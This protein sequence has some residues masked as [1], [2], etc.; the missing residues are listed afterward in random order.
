MNGCTAT[1]GTVTI[2]PQLTATSVLT[3]E[4]DCSAS[5][6]AVIDVTIN[7]GYAPFA[8]QVNGGASTPVVGNAFTYTTATD[9]TFVFTITD[10]EGCTAETTVVVDPITNPVATHNATDP[11]C[12]GASDGQVEILIDTNFG[13]APYQ[14]DFD[15]AGF[16][17]QTVFSNLAAGTYNYLSLIHI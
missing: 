17:T 9:G 2:E 4:L 8:Y 13:T 16:G 15:G 11:A 1:S 10:A 5:P 12:A 14:V 3:K 6:D 7:G